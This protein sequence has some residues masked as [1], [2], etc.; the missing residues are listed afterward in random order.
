MSAVRVRCRTNLDGYDQEKWPTELP[1]TP[2]IGHMVEA[3]PRRAKTFG[4]RL[5]I[6]QLTWCA[7]G[8]LELELHLRRSSTT[9]QA[10]PH[11][12]MTRADLEAWLEAN[13]CERSGVIDA[14]AC[15]WSLVDSSDAVDQD[16]YERRGYFVCWSGESIS[17]AMDSIERVMGVRPG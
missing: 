6:V 8:S 11:E 13:G 1:G 3:Q 16:A 4:M 10:Q 9:V 5:K 2:A 15:G 14:P 12:T 7:D 17:V